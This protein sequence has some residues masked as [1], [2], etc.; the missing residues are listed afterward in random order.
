MCS[1][2]RDQHG[3]AFVDTPQPHVDCSIEV[4]HQPE[5]AGPAR[6]GLHLQNL[7]EVVLFVEALE[8]APAEVS[9]Q[10]ARREVAE[11]RIGAMPGR[12]HRW[13]PDSIAQ[14]KQGLFPL[15]GERGTNLKQ[16]LADISHQL[17]ALDGT[18]VARD[19]SSS[20][21]RQG[22]TAARPGAHS[23]RLV[24]RCATRAGISGRPSASPTILKAC[25]YLSSNMWPMS[26]TP[27]PATPWP[28][29]GQQEKLLWPCA[30]LN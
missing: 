26:M 20:R 30:S 15:V 18:A 11:A 12:A 9:L 24:R 27:S 6:A 1:L 16:H 29:G 8:P 2:A 23:R 3:Q 10:R 25:E 17:V 22:G 5:A 28:T 4:R 19:A 14:S 13:H 21:L 7:E